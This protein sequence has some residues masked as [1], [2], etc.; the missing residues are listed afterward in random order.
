MNKYSENYRL[1]LR[2]LSKPPRFNNPD[3][4]GK[5]EHPRQLGR[6]ELDPIIESVRVRSLH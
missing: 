1:L 5:M 4:T 3:S 6:V 2:E